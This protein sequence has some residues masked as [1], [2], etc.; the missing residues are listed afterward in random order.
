MI[1]FGHLV[2]TTKLVYRTL[3]AVMITSTIFCN[4]IRK[5]FNN[6]QQTDM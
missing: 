1:C 2:N 4:S 6:I 5:V 3:L